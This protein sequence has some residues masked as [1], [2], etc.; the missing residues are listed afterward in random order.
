MRD[1]GH[2]Q[3]TILV[4]GVNGQVGFELLRTLQGLGRVYRSGQGRD[5]H[6]RGM[7]AECRR[8]ARVR[9]RTGAYRRHADSLQGLGV[10][11]GRGLG[12][13]AATLIFDW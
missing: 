10:Y 11:E 6:R 1:G 2:R 9:G 3:P 12:G 5:R 4:T 13:F 8:A 7:A